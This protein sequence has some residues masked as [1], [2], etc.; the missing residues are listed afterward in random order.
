MGRGGGGRGRE[1]GRGTTTP[2]LVNTE[3]SK[4]CIAKSRTFTSPGPFTF[5]VS[6]SVYHSVHSIHTPSYAG[7]L[8]SSLLLPKGPFSVCYPRRLLD[9]SYKNGGTQAKNGN[10]LVYRQLAG[11]G[12][13]LPAVCNC[14]PF[15][16]STQLIRLIGRLIRALHAKWLLPADASTS[17]VHPTAGCPYLRR[18]VWC[19]MRR[20]HTPS[21]CKMCLRCRNNLQ[22]KLICSPFVAVCLI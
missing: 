11:H 10:N 6:R 8:F 2:F 13:V 12:T 16:R 22:M 20:G 15:L 18:P 9:V 7:L 4:G 19:P 17:R 21:L 5:S 1:G 3:S 14:S